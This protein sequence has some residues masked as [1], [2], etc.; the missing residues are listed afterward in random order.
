MQRCEEL[1]V[2]IGLSET[3]RS[4]IALLEKVAKADGSNSLNAEDEV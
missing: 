4:N 2:Q 1:E 3:V